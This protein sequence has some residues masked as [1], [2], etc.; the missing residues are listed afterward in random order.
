MVV[1]KRGYSWAGLS[2]QLGVCAMCVCVGVGKGDIQGAARCVHH[3][4]CVWVC[5]LYC[6][7]GYM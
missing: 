7:C 5:A 1:P 3:V 4:V 6:G 2:Q